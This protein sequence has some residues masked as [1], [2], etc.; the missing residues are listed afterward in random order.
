MLNVPKLR[1]LLEDILHHNTSFEDIVIDQEFPS[2]GRKVLVLK[3]RRL[4]QEAIMPARI[5]LVIDDITERQVDNE[6]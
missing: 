3:A 4:E 5:L 1:Q 6:R 2:L